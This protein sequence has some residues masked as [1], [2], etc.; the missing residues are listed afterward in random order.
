MYR[1]RLV[2]PVPPRSTAEERAGAG[3][4]CHITFAPVLRRCGK[5]QKGPLSEPW[6][7]IMLGNASVSAIGKL[8]S[9]IWSSA[10]ARFGPS[11][12]QDTM[13][14]L[15]RASFSAR[16]RRA[17]SRHPSTF[18]RSLLLE[19]QDL[20][21]WILP[22]HFSTFIAWAGRRPPAPVLHVE[23][24][25]QSWPEASFVSYR[26]ASTTP[27]FP[28]CRIAV[29]EPHQTN[30]STGAGYFELRARM[31]RRNRSHQGG[32]YR[33]SEILYNVWACSPRS[34]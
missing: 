27:V 5:R 10:D 23:A 11:A 16:A 3:V 25:S 18:V 13:L 24:S 29:P 14:Q 4:E 22:H 17:R 19:K 31:A 26:E 32:P 2:Q 9:S 20:F 7:P 15:R 33:V 34:E 21:A 1:G 28:R 12:A 8:R 6:E 30:I